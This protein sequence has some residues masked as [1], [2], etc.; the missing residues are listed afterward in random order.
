MTKRICLLGTLW[1]MTAALA[2]TPADEPAAVEAQTT[3]VLEASEADAGQVPFDVINNDRLT[4]DW[5]GAR[6]WL[7]E[8]GIE[9]GLSMTSY[10]QHNVHGGVQTHNGHRI[11]GSVDYELTLDFET[12]GL[13]NGGILYVGAESSWADGISDRVGDWFGVNGDAAGDEAIV[14]PELWYEQ[15]FFDGKARVRVGKMDV[16][17]DFDTNAY[18]NDETAQ[19][20][21]AALINVGNAPFPDV[22]LGA[23]LVVQPWDWF[24]FGIVAADAQADGRETGLNT[25]FHDEDHFFG[26]MEFG[27]LPV[28]D[29]PWGELPGGYRFLIW[30]D[31]QPKAKFFNDLGGRR[32]T[33]PMKRDDVG[34]VFNM[35]Q[36]LFKERPD[37]AADSQ[38]LGLFFRY[39][40]AHQDVNEVEHFWSIGA[41]YQGLIPT[42]DD[43]VLG[44]GF[45]QGILSDPLHD[46]DGGHRESVYEL[47][48][49]AYVLP[50]LSV[51][52]DLQYIVNPGMGDGNDAFVMGC[53]VQMSF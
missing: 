26:M 43:D 4:G 9:F 33:V 10:Y 44:F 16:T 32:R 25:T 17:A 11:T 38:G 24:Y 2:Q 50:W 49:N 19:F 6:T 36:M 15:M 1:T 23:Q 37:D 12:M 22:G 51:T 5:W 46:L 53:R 40:Y 27:F 18:A 8:R 13:W 3:D 21:N 47:Y 20:L 41:Q 28:W 45:A 39:G 14:V 7:E 30:Y 34:F 48:Y 42:R 31:P 35:D 29:T 52:P